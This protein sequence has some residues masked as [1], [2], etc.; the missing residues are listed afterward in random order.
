[1]K[2]ASRRRRRVGCT[3]NTEKEGKGERNHEREIQEKDTNRSRMQRYFDCQKMC[4][5]EITM[6]YDDLRKMKEIIIIVV[7]ARLKV[8]FF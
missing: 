1:M 5:C 7:I 3:R 8:D 6:N 2:E 4:V